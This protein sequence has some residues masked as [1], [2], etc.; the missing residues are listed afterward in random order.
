MKRWIRRYWLRLLACCGLAYCPADAFLIEPHWVR[1]SRLSFSEHPSMRIVHISD[2]HYKGDRAYLQ[3]I[4]RKVNSLQ[5]DAVCFTGDIVENTRYLDDA[6]EALGS[7]KAP[8]YGVPGNHEYWSGAPFEKIAEA[9]RKTSGEWLVDRSVTAANGALLIEGRS[10][11][12]I[13]TQRAAS[14]LA[15]PGHEI[16]WA[17][18][19]GSTA[20][21]ADPIGTAKP[22][23]ARASDAPALAPKAKKILLT[24]YP[25]LTDSIKGGAYDLILAG[26]AH[27]GQVR[28]PLF[29]AL[30]VPFGVGRYQAGAYSTPAGRLHVSSG[31]GTFLLPV[32]LFCRPEI[33]LIEM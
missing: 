18:A 22:P 9:F 16:D 30:I 1:I 15:M 6:L 10:G 23:A 21:S 25:A 29:G 14:V 19:P 28:L 5:A 17:P 27:G 20:A 4:L 26:H 33:T 24:H 2:L 13:N 11:M 3:V 12:E 31:L 8:L 32:R 7:I